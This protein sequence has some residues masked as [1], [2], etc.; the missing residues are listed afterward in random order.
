MAGSPKSVDAPA[1]SSGGT[2]SDLPHVPSS[3]KTVHWIG[4]FHLSVVYVVWGSTY[5]AI[6]VA[7]RE[8][9]GFPPFTMV[10][11]RVLV[12]GMLLLLWSAGN[13]RRIRLSR[14]EF[15]VLA[16]SGLLLWLGG[17]GLVT[18]AEQ[19]ADSGYAALLIAAVP[20]WVAL[21]EAVLDWTIPS[22]L[23]IGS[24][25]VGF[26]GIVLLSVP[27]LVSGAEAD[28]WSLIA[29]LLAGLSWAS[30]TLVQSRNP[31][32]LSPRVSSGYQQ[33]IAG[34]GLVVIAMALR[35]SQPDPIREA[36]L[37]WGYLVIL[38]SVFAFTSFVQALRLLPINV[39]MTYAYINPVIA[40]ILGWV[41]LREPI[42]VWTLGGAALVLLGVAG[43]FKTRYS[44]GRVPPSTRAS[45]RR[46]N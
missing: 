4:L 27:A 39:A 37:A 15:A 40:M 18:W 38:G 25:L 26:V 12:G 1:R 16:A 34:L 22:P 21:I 13:R 41:I 46:D 19:R 32:T 14:R 3:E 5:L 9:S 43:V 35:E 44:G 23:L 8:G 30:G 36:W 2:H 31:V 33:F 45:I 6:R 20:I 29:L 42:T 24:L 11:L 17:N 7:V 10:G 28:L